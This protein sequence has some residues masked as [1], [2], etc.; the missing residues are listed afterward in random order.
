MCV[1]A[2]LTFKNVRTQV[3]QFAG[4]PG[5]KTRGGEEAP[6]SRDKSRVRCVTCL[7][8]TRT[9]RRDKI[10]SVP[11]RFVEDAIAEHF[12]TTSSLFLLSLVKLAS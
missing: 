11:H 8:Q 6:R 9:V 5:G 10:T 1:K 7:Y 4:A 3:K 12:P 2:R